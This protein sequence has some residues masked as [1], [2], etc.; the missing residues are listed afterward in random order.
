MCLS[1]PKMPKPPPPPKPPVAPPPPTPMAKTVKRPARKARRE[2]IRRG[3]PLII[4][5]GSGVNAGG[6]QS[7][8]G[9]Y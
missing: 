8:A 1:A 3:N 6:M 9:L 5:R 7:G 2:Q 4:S